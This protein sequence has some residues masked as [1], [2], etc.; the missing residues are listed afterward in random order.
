MKSFYFGYKK[1]CVTSARA[2]EDKNILQ[3]HLF[4]I[5]TNSNY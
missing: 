2:A 5:I 3:E 4:L 1:V